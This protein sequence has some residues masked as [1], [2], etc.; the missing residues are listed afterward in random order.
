[1]IFNNVAHHACHKVMVVA[2]TFH[3][4][5]VIFH[6]VAHQGW[7]HSKNDYTLRVIARTFHLMCIN[8]HNGWS[9]VHPQL[10]TTHTMGTQK[11]MVVAS[12]FHVT[13]MIFHNVKHQGCFLI[14]LPHSSSFLIPH[15]FALP[16]KWG[17]H[18]WS[19]TPFHWSWP[20][21]PVPA[22]ALY[23]IASTIR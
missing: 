21:V 3:V 8:F 16:A 18:I 9:H 17:S 4:T 13:C 23:T 2:R 12:T 22:L 19:K 6:N 1:M 10:A 20:S 15:T 7:L 5:W 11:L 14:L